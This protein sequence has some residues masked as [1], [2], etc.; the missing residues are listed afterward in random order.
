MF[1][2]LRYRRREPIR[3]RNRPVGENAASATPVTASFFGVN[4]AT[5]QEFA[6]ADHQVA[7]IVA[8]I[9]ILNDVAEVLAVAGR[10]ATWVDC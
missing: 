1:V 5:L 9:V 8:R 10:P 2:A 7:V 4:A 3:M 6:H